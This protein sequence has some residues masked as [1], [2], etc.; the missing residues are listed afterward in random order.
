MDCDLMNVVD[1]RTV[2]L[3]LDTSDYAAMYIA[4]PGTPFAK[5]YDE[6]HE[7]NPSDLG[8]SYHVVFEL[9]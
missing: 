8:L 6:L 2:R 3:H 5:V 4:A 1:R 9:L 7:K